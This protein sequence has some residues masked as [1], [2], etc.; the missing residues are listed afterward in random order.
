MNVSFAI[1]KELESY[2]EIQLQSGNYDTV[3]DYFLM[4]LQQDKLRKDAQ[5]NI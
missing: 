5:A 1:P 2:L 3:A 4:L